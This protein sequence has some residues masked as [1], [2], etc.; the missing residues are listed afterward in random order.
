MSL[1]KLAGQTAWYGMSNIAARLLTYLLTPYLTYTLSG[2]AGQVEFGKQAFFYALFPVLNIIYTYGMETSYFRFSLREDAQHVYRNILSLLGLTTL[3]FTLVMVSFHEPLARFAEIPGQSEY[4][5]WAAGIIGLDAL[6]AL[7]FARLRQENRPRNY[8][9]VKVVGIVVFVGLIV[10]QFQWGAVMA[11]RTPDH[12]MAGWYDRHWGLGFILFANL[13]QAALS[14]LMLYKSWIKDIRFSLD[15]KLIAQILPYGI[16]ILLAGFAGTINDSLNR[17]LFQK[18]YP[19]DPETSLRQLGFFTAALRLSIVINLMIQA[20]RLAAE[21]F[22]FSVAGQKDARAIYARVMKWF[23]IL[24]SIAFLHVTLYLD[25]WQL[26]I[27]APY[28]E[29]LDLVPILL[30]SYLLFG[31]YNNLTVWYKLTDKTRYGTYIMGIGAIVTG[32]I[33]YFGIPRWGYYACALAMLASN[34]VMVVLAYLWGQK[35]Y[36]I[37]YRVPYLFTILL[38]M[39]GVFLIQWTL[40]SFT[41]HI[42]LRLSSATLLFFGYLYWIYRKER[43]EIQSLGIIRRQGSG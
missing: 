16:P 27:A 32:L 37:P 7:P 41:D 40:F 6:A 20:F 24:V 4:I 42:G 19:A 33:C 2:P 43:V 36:P 25:L 9:F 17:I 11:E 38:G 1:R 34:A 29:A 8:A 30:F 12:F 39:I 5:Y 31:I 26:F 13:V 3:I 22:F 15:L 23:L 21:P 35:Y 28:R 18:L 10:L 14:L